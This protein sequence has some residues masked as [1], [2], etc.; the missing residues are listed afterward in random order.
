MRVQ[1]QIYIANNTELSLYPY[2]QQEHIVSR[3]G[4]FFWFLFTLLGVCVFL[5]D[6]FGCLL[7]VEQPVVFM[8]QCFQLGVDT[9]LEVTEISY[10]S[11]L[12]AVFIMICLENESSVWGSFLGVCVHFG[13]Q[14][15]FHL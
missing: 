10:R 5:R 15:S 9:V 13:F 1:N 6:R 14:F 7:V 8:F 2:P 12:F 11:M 4:S 3:Y